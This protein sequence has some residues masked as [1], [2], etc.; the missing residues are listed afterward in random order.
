MVRLSR[1]SASKVTR[2]LNVS[3]PEPRGRTS[4]LILLFLLGGVGES[5]GSRRL[6]GSEYSRNDG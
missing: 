3:R 4:D 2:L 1:A 6:S 5:S